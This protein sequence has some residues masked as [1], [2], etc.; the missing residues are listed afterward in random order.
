M[1]MLGW[2]RLL[3]ASSML[4]VL[5][6]APGC[7][8]SSGGGGDD[9]AVGDVDATDPGD[10]G[11]V[12]PVDGTGDGADSGEV[13]VG[14][15]IA[16]PDVPG[17]DVPDPG[18][19][20]SEDVVQPDGACQP[21]CADKE[22]G[23][24]G[25]GGSCGS[26]PAAAPY[27]NDFTCGFDC[28]PDC[29]DQACGDDGCDGSCGLCPGAQDACVDGACMCVPICGDG[30]CGDDGCG[31]S[32]GGCAIDE[33]CVDGLC[34]GCSCDDKEC[35]DDGCGNDCGSCPGAAPYCYD[36][37]CAVDC[38]S[39]CEGKLCGSDGCDGYCGFCTGDQEQ[40]IA[41]VCACVPT[42][43]DDP[44]ACGDNGCG[45]SCGTCDDGSS[46]TDG[47]CAACSCDDKECGLDQCGNLCGTCPAAAP[48]C[49]D[50]AC[51]VGCAPDCLGKSCAPDSTDGDGCG[52]SCK[53]CDEDSW[54]SMDDEICVACDCGADVCGEDPCGNPCG[55]CGEGLSCVGGQCIEV[56]IPPLDCPDTCTG[57][58]IA[59]ALC[60]LD[61]CYPELVGEVSIASPTA[62]NINGAWKA[63]DHYGDADND[64][65]PKGG[66]SYLI[67]ASGFVTSSS[68]HHDKLWG[69]VG[70][71]D[72]YGATGDIINDAVSVSIP[73]L[74]PPGATGFSLD[75]VFMSQEY[76]EWIGSQFNDKFYLVL[77][78]PETTGGFDE[79]I[80]YTACSNPE[81][82][83]DG[84][85]ADGTKWCYISINNAWS[86]PCA[87]PVTNISGTGFEC[88]ADGS[89]TGWMRTSWPIEGGESFLLTLHIHD[90]GDQ[91]YD[92]AAIIDNFQ[93]LAG[94]FEPG[95]VG[96]AP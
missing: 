8:T 48:W 37:A 18:V 13:V 72:P 29:A 65:K 58:T 56:S 10:G 36:G 71:V 1:K 77:H 53:G 50:N 51:T 88:G 45:A 86:E 2:T 91:V 35:G 27:C 76:E 44:A 94:D 17:P 23:D 62:A 84:E 92:S 68:G 81:D 24:D 83:F 69:N 78:A 90:M 16:V 54:C 32:C 74:A 40:C 43:A 66:E 93:W 31:G 75:T 87:N 60:G 85:D 38:I 30:A 70:A 25:C 14:P 61:I 6:F 42:C 15:D 57:A 59:A 12:I 4:L 67:I 73:L 41:G 20:D 82:Y 63:V 46:C 7:D 47:L 64:L 28:V 79:I 96:L 52:G 21:T 89:S 55:A 26:C 49:S 22:C 80:N 9:D 11:E 19:P 33:V 34:S 95:T 5:G 39:D 3:A